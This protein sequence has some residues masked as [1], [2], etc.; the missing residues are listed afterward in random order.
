MLYEMLYGLTFTPWKGETC[1]QL[2]QNIQN[3][4]LSFPARPFVSE[5]MKE[6]IRGMLEKT[7]SKRFGWPE[8]FEHPV[9]ANKNYL[10]NTG[11]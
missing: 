6:L 11:Q 2:A 7:E 10:S 1:V 9:I 3:S 5:T 8:V 4:D